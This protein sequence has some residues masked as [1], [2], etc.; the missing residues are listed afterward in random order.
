MKL[1]K[2]FDLEKTKK[3]IMEE[4][5]YVLFVSH[6][7]ENNKDTTDMIV[8]STDIAR[9]NLDMAIILNKENQE[10]VLKMVNSNYANLNQLMQLKELKKFVSK[11]MK[12]YEKWVVQYLKTELVENYFAPIF[13]S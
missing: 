1:T 7:T 13:E 12:E 4:M 11:N 8:L 3:E 5:Q 2:T 10:E 6:I 9:Q